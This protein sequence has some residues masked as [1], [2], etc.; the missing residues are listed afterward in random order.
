MSILPT[1]ILPKNILTALRRPANHIQVSPL[2]AEVARCD[3]QEV[4]RRLETGD[5]GLSEEEAARRLEQHGPNVVAKEQRFRRLRLLGQACA[6]PLVILLLVLAAL[7]WW[8]DEISAGRPSCWPWSSWGWA[9]AS[10]RNRG[11]TPPRP[12]SRP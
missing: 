10:S 8:T 6:N 3:A 4:F 5:K 2:L 12:S 11:P 7:S 1:F 9:C